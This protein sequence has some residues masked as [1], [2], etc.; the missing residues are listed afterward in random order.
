MDRLK[1]LIAG[2]LALVAFLALMSLAGAPRPEEEAS[3][4][5][6]RQGG[7]C[8]ELERWGLFG[9]RTTHQAYSI[10]DV[11]YARWHRPVTEPPCDATDN[12]ASRLIRVP[13]DTTPGVYRICGLD[14]ER[15]C[16]EFR[17]VPFEPGQPGP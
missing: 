3:G 2:V 13:L 9:W 15:G 8:V 6:R 10:T 7:A 11:V 16:V 5:V 14:D 17:M 4:I 1:L 12:Q